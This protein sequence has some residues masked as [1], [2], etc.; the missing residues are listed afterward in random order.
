MHDLAIRN[1]LIVDGTGKPS[2][3]GDLAVENGQVVAR[4]GEVGSARETID[5]DGL[6]LAPGIVDTHTHFDAQLTWD[7]SAS[8]S[9]SLGVTTV[10]IGNCGFTIAPCREQDRDATLRNLTHVEGM[11]LSALRE[12]VRWEFESFPEYLDLLARCGLV[13]NVASYIGHSSVRT[14]VMGEAATEREATDDEISRMADI[15][16]ASVTAGAIGFSTTTFEGHNGENGVPMPSRFASE[17][18]VGALV[19]AMGE[20]GR[21]IFMLTAGSGTK[22]GTLEKMAAEARR[23]VLV[24]AFLHNPTRPDGVRLGLARLDAAAKRGNEMWGQV[25]CRPLSL[26]FTMA[27]PYLFEGLSAWKPAMTADGTEGLKSVYASGEFRAAVRAELTVP[28]KVRIFNGDWEKIIVREV[29]P[30]GDSA[31]EQRSLRDLAT[32]AGQDP[33]DWLLD[34]AIDGGLDTLFVAQL[35]NTDEK[36]V[37]EALVHDRSLVSL[38]DAGAHLTFFC[39]AGFGLHLLGHWVR[40]RELF[41]LEEGV[42]RLSGRLADIMRIPGRGRLVPG[43]AADMMLFD[44]DRV[45]VGLSKRVHD[46]PSGAPRLVATAEGLHGV[47]VNGIRVT[48]HEGTSVSGAMPGQLVRSF[49]A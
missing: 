35:L 18:E 5:A 21:G 16:R 30:G 48:S 38:S 4:G 27:S 6:A 49:H 36:A 11:S 47:W 17:A 33:L 7:P 28:A 15:V 31:L 19:R 40:D 24:A 45:G 9:P 23:P 10:V 46:L 29:T 12:G 20:T 22:L 25:S 26:E 42:H 37:S 32:T 3:H 1:A 2:F 44:P 39:D 13:P 41:S 34:H 43:Q 8:P 14:Y